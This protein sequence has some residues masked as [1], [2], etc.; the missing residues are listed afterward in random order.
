MKRA[1]KYIPGIVRNVDELGRIVIPHEARDLLSIAIKDPLEVYV[2]EEDGK[3]VVILKK[4]CAGCVICNA[5]DNCIR[6]N[7]KLVCRECIEE[8][9]G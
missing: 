4:Y 5:M 3:P 9:K 2:G 1:G 6:F 8:L 7:G